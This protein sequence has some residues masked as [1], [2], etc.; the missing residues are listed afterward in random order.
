MNKRFEK[1]LSLFLVFLF[2]FSSIPFNSFIVHAD[3]K[4]T[5]KGFI[6][7]EEEYFSYHAYMFIGDN[8]KKYVLV[9]M[10][11]KFPS[12]ITEESCSGRSRDST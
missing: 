4:V 9:D 6:T 10:D 12:N 5:L 8:L 3:D 11:N 1:V 7:R 2:V